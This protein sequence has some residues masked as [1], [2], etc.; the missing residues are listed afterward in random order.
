MSDTVYR[1]IREQV[2]DRIRNDVLAGELGAG[3][4]LREQALAE[5]YGVS[6]G[7]IR[8]ALL[9]LTQEGV[10]VAK[11]NC[12][13]SVSHPPAEALQPLIVDVRRR[14]EAFALGRAMD[15]IGADD[16]AHLSQHVA[17]L[18][19]ACREG[20]MAGIVRHDM[21]FHRRLVALAGDEDLVAVWL[22]IIARMMLHYTRHETLMD[23]YREHA[24]ILAAIER[25]DRTG[26]T[27][28]LEN[29]IQ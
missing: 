13:V 26:A 22:P 27:Q 2:V 19:E 14:I 15:V 1:T 11:P 18:R 12:G 21:A 5:R 9:Q 20:D 25:G 29:N 3:E 6:R 4:R 23:S 24:A 10:L 17:D 16:I 8:D 28:A 7:P